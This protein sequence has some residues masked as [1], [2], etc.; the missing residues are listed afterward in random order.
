[1]SL[2]L[3]AVRQSGRGRNRGISFVN[4]LEYFF[5][6]FLHFMLRNLGC[7]MSEKYAKKSDFILTKFF[8][9]NIIRL[10]N[11]QSSFADECSLSSVGRATDC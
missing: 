7:E 8:Q 2:A 6:R 3:L 1:M 4:R 10:F 9:V 11:L 5:W